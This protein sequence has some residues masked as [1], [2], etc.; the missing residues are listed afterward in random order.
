MFYKLQYIQT[1]LCATNSTTTSATS[2]QLQQ[3]WR[4]MNISF[5]HHVLHQTFPICNSVPGP[6]INRM[7]RYMLSV[8]PLAQAGLCGA[9]G[10]DTNT[11]CFVVLIAWHMSFRNN[12]RNSAPLTPSQTRSY[13]FVGRLAFPFFIIKMCSCQKTIVH[14]LAIASSSKQTNFALSR[15]PGSPSSNTLLHAS[16]VRILHT[17][18]VQDPFASVQYLVQ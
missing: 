12:F 9:L 5:L 2:C 8:T 10:I 3:I 14:A 7:P 17:I 1:Q 18:K 16:P 11:W 13:L 6:V 15:D 4:A